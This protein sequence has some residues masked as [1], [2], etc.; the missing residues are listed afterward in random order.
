VPGCCLCEHHWL[1]LVLTVIKLIDLHTRRACG[2]IHL[3]DAGPY[4][5]AGRMAPNHT[6]GFCFDAVA[7]MLQASSTKPEA[8]L[9]LSAGPAFC[10]QG[11]RLEGW[12]IAT[13]NHIETIKQSTTRQAC[14]SSAMHL[15]Q[16]SARHAHHFLKLQCCCSSGCRSRMC[17]Q[18]YQLHCVALHSR[19]CRRLC[20][21]HPHPPPGS[22]HWCTGSP[23]WFA[24]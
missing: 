7:V 22:N 4:S 11:G 19:P 21:R 13:L 6:G 16:N 18:P 8:P 5:S 1:L 17:R 9:L 15:V 10:C 20:P 24:L 2:C 3:A 23:S 12:V 14:C